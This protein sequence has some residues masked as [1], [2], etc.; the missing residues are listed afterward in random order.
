MPSSSVTSSESQLPSALQSK[1]SLARRLRAQLLQHRGARG[2]P[3]ATVQSPDST[4]VARPA[5]ASIA[6]RAGS[7]SGC[8][9]HIRSARLPLRSSQSRR[10]VARFFA[11]SMSSS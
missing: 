7:G 3:R 8:R 4:S 6:Q 10:S 11:S 5:R 9:A 2:A 1:P